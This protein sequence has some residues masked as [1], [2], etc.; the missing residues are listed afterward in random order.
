MNGGP[1]AEATRSRG[2]PRDESK[3]RV[4][5]DALRQV[6]IEDGY[7]GATIPNVARRAGVGA[8]TVYRR[9]STQVELVETVF[10]EPVTG[11]VELRP[12]DFH[13][14]L[15]QL[16]SGA[17]EIFGDVATRSA[18]PGLLVEYQ[19]D[20][21]RYDALVTRLEAPAREYFRAS[22]A[23]GIESGVV[24][25]DSDPDLLFDLIVGAAIFRGLV[26]GETGAAATDGIVSAIAAAA[27]PRAGGT[28]AK[29]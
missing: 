29:A 15:E 16:V 23:R 4:V 17:V 24:D 22:H 27:S 25:P 20:E 28:A 5:R 12:T 9:W 14:A 10:D 13:E 7:R 18:V 19:S 1:E 21:A 3:D 8:P 11:V 2:R 6:L 26:R